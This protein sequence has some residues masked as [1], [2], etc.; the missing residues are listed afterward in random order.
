MNNEEYHQKIIE[1][2][3]FIVEKREAQRKREPDEVIVGIE[4][5]INSINQELQT[6]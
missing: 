3:K 5:K 1:K 6:A 2:Q 4:K